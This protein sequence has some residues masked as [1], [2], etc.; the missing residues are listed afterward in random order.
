M[1]SI[2]IDL[3]KDSY[4]IHIEKGLLNQ[5]G[6]YVRQLTEAERLAVITDDAVDALYGNQLQAALEQSG[7]EVHRIV[8]KAGEGSKNMTVLAD[9]YQGL[10]DAGITRSD[11]IIT[12]GGGV[13]GDLGGLAAATYLRGIPFIQIPTTIIA[14]V[15]SSVGGKVAVD[16]PSG[17]NQAGAFYQPKGVLIDPELLTTLPLRFI[18]DGLGEV[19]KYGC[20]R[21]NHLFELLET[22]QDD[23]LS[24]H[25]EEIIE[26]C[27]TIKARIVEH[28]VLDMGERMLLNFGHTIGHAIERCYGY[29]YYT[30]GEGVAAGMAML[31]AVTEQKGL[32]AA[33]TTQR[34]DAVLQRYGLPVTVNA[35][36]PQLLPYIA[37]DKKKRGNR[38][39]LVIIPAI[40]TSELLSIEGDAIPDY[41]R[42]VDAQ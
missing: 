4:D 6:Q 29:G 16:L 26:C 17:K 3:G 11:A 25:W 31:T 22:L 41:I 24:A 1:R 23:T 21:D 5:S 10:A 35:A 38:L 8:F 39:T 9:L 40:G 12:F 14:Q 7:Y 30:H 27:C 18:H 32:T 33:G 37:H 19:I 36:M 34:L 20:I 28:D 15:D 2:H 13:P 42:K